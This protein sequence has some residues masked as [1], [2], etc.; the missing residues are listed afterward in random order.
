MMTTILHTQTTNSSAIPQ[1]VTFKTV[2]GYENREQ[3][4]RDVFR[5]SLE[6]LYGSQESALKKIVNSDGRKAR[7]MYEGGQP[8]GILVYKTNLSD[9]FSDLGVSNS[10]EVKTLFLIDAEKNSGKGLGSALLKKVISVAKE[11]NADSIHLTVS[12]KKPESLAFFSKKEFKVIKEFD[13]LYLD[14]VKEFL[15]KLD[16]K[17][18]PKKIVQKRKREQEEPVSVKKQTRPKIEKPVNRTFYQ[19]VTLK[20]PYVD[21]IKSGEKTVEGRINSGMFAKV[22]PGEGI[23]FFNHISE[24]YCT[25]DNVSKYRSFEEM[26]REEGVQNCLPGVKSLRDGVSIYD[27][28]KGYSDRAK[29][30]GVVALKLH[31]DH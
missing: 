31:V 27:R 16:L 26:L 14:G 28:I 7:L 17:K 9:E 23:K 20:H 6:P 19:S 5:K 1:E 4:V 25:I 12:E 30:S 15:L 22:R 11:K 18:E 29:K 13:S 21:Q 24:V 8:S 10:L 3:I 2:R